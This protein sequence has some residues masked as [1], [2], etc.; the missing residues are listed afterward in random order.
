M[1][2]KRCTWLVFLVLGIGQSASADPTAAVEQTLKAYEV[3]WSHHD[4]RAIASFYYE[5]AMRVSSGG[6]VVRATRQDQENFFKTFLPALVKS[7]YDRSEWDS[8]K[9]ALL[10]ETT[11]IASGITVRYRV[12]GSVFERVGVTYAL[13]NTA[14]GWKIFLSATHTPGS[15]LKLP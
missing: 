14:D 12:D 4:A 15:V 10:D 2:A 9:V 13:Y 5:P 7:G 1:K 11:A 6:P 3:A 8:L